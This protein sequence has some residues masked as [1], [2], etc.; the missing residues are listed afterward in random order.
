MC[1]KWSL[2]YVCIVNPLSGLLHTSVPLI[3][4]LKVL[5]HSM[6]AKCYFF[7]SFFSFKKMWSPRATGVWCNRINYMKAMK[8]GVNW[9]EKLK[10][11]KVNYI[12]KQQISKSPYIRYVASLYG[13]S[14]HIMRSRW[15][16]QVDVCFTLTCHVCSLSLV[17]VHIVLGGRGG[18]IDLLS[19]MNRRGK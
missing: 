3:H 5:W 9:S 16:R 7:F 18:F 17:Y 14:K 1:T 12:F 4:S 2:I 13:T 6:S 19:H 11:I 8:D 15:R 10:E